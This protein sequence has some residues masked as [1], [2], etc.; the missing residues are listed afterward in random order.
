MQTLVLTEIATGWTECAPLL[1]R[2]QR[3]LTPTNDRREPSFP[4]TGF[5]ETLKI[6]VEADLLLNARRR[7]ALPPDRIQGLPIANLSGPEG[8]RVRA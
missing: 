4:A 1:E 6:L 8:V 3:R 7:V 5:S 2:E